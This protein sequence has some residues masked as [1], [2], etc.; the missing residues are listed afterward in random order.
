MTDLADH[1]TDFVYPSYL[2]LLCIQLRSQG[3]LYAEVMCIEY[4]W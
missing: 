4:T 1:L 2:V 3:N